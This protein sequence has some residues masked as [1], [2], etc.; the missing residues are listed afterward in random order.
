MGTGASIKNDNKSSSFCNKSIISN[1]LKEP[2]CNTKSSSWLVC[3][4]GMKQPFAYQTQCDDLAGSILFRLVT[5]YEMYY[6]ANRKRLQRE[7][8]VIPLR[9]DDGDDDSA[10]PSTE[11]SCCCPIQGQRRRCHPHDKNNKHKALTKSRKLMKRECK[12]SAIQQA[13]QEVFSHVQFVRQTVRQPM[14]QATNQPLSNT[15]I[16]SNLATA[17]MISYI[18]DN[19]HL[20]SFRHSHPPHHTNRIR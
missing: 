2:C 19:P 10:S 15:T 17:K 16:P 11:G 12:R 18:Q 7:L 1:H 6:H 8:A 5:L 13:F 14:S 4:D 9:D 3:I 20:F